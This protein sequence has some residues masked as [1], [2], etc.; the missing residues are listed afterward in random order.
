MADPYFRYLPEFE[1]VNRTKEGRSEGDYSVVKIFLK[2]QNL[3]RIY[4]KN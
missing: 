1:Y 4:F 2:E 3:E